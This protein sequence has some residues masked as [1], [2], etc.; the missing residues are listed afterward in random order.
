MNTHRINWI[1]VLL[2]RLTIGIVFIQSGQ[3]K[4]SNMDKVIGYF[5]ELMIPLPTFSAYLT[6]WTE[7]I[8]GCF[9]LL[10]FL[11][12]VSALALFIIMSVAVITTQVP[13][14]ENATD[15]LGT[16]EYLYALMCLGLILLGAEKISLDALVK[17][18]MQ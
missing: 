7:L 9:I 13:N 6:A 3:G 1:F 11:T 10:G 16:V 4:I 8:A 18:K 15:I 5:S 17:S 2:I 12:R 14:L